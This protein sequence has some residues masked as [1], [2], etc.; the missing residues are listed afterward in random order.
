MSLFDNLM[1]PISPEI[2]VDVIKFF[3]NGSGFY[4]NLVVEL[5]LD[6][7]ISM[8]TADVSD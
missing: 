3:G 5:A 6:N 4:I 8:M 1:T 2:L 7:A